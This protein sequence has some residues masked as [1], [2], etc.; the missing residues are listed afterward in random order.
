MKFSDK[1]IRKI[2]L[3]KRH[4]KIIQLYLNGTRIIDIARI[5]GG[6]RKRIRKVI[7]DFKSSQKITQT[8][9]SE[10]NS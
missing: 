6:C 4:Q 5:L 1:V 3:L 8:K 10:T 7:V 9:E 2:N